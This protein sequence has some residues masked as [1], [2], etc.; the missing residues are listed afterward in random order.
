MATGSSGL[1]R[2]I[3]SDAVALTNP[4]PSMAS[5]AAC[6]L[7]Q[8]LVPREFWVDDDWGGR[9]S[10]PSLC[11]LGL[12]PLRK[13]PLLDRPLRETQDGSPLTDASWFSVP[14]TSEHRRGDCPS[15]LR[16]ERAVAAT[17]GTRPSGR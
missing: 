7:T 9:P 16:G 1:G 3:A 4:T 12:L 8:E 11:R 17:Q 5:T 2:W 6:L 10:S 13:A 15:C 14:W